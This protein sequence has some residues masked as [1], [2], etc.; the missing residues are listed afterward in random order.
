MTEGRQKNRVREK[1]VK[2]VKD[3]WTKGGG[4]KTH[5]IDGGARRDAMRRVQT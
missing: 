2:D 1:K 4:S 5:L 3:W